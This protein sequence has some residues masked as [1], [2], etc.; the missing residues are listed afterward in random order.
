[1]PR[2][3]VVKLS[4]SL[5]DSMSRDEVKG[6]CGLLSKLRCRDVQPF[7]VAGGGRVAREYIELARSF[8][9][10]EAYLDEVGIEASRLNAM[11]IIACLGA[12]AYPYPPKT[13]E[14]YVKAAESGRIVVS[15]GLQPGQ[16]TNAVAAIVAERLHADL[17]INATDVDGIYTADP[18]VNRSA[19]KIDVIE[20]REL[21]RML[22]SKEAEAGTY[23]LLD[24]VAAK[25]IERSGIKVRVVKCT[26]EAIEAAVMGKDIGTLIVEGADRG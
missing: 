21:V 12:E 26:P 2:K 11:I 16:S 17:F 24:L 3:I 10:N 13:L 19:K 25:I 5:F 8:G 15:G 20:A 23:D 18:R 4:G 1:M 6:I 9:A 14:E 7:I 22:S